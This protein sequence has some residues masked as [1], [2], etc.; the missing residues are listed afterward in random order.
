MN[1]AGL[2]TNNPLI[3]VIVLIYNNQ[4]YL[5][6]AIKSIVRQTYKKIEIIISD[7]GSDDFNKE[8][9]EC[10]VNKYCR[11]INRVLINHNEKN[12][13][14]V[15]H[16]NEILKKANGD[17]IKLLACDDCIADKNVF[18]EVAVQMMKSDA[19]IC[20]GKA[21]WKVGNK[22]LRITPYKHERKLFKN[23]NLKLYKYICI[24]NNCIPAPAA[25][26]KKEV[27]DDYRLDLDILL[28]EDWPLWIRYLSKGGVIDFIDINVVFYNVGGVSTNKIINY[29][30]MSD[31]KIIYKK[32]ILSN[33][34]FTKKE[35]REATY[36]YHMNFSKI[37]GFKKM[38]FVMRHIDIAIRRKYI[39]ILNSYSF[40]TDLLDT[41][42]KQ[43][44]EDNESS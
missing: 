23:Q 12:Q 3:S 35:K 17:I 27:F 37:S 40:L 39:S 34:I 42:Y 38:L 20:I 43:V 8:Y 22:I 26:I 29:K 10:L 14:T 9:I 2:I 11:T 13:G 44:E 7:D 24:V 4:N 5:E 1:D 15:K 16:I 32:Y 36:I 31:M 41:R 25:F 33:L 28:I 21:V 6:N 19:K 30:L 18:Q